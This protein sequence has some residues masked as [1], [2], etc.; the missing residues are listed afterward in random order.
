[1]TRNKKTKKSK[2]ERGKKKIR[3]RQTQR[4][5]VSTRA[6]FKETKIQTKKERHACTVMRDKHADAQVRA[7]ST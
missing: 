7:R 4:E 2:S 1:M 5:N 6:T 3:E